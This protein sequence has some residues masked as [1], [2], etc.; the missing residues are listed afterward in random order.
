MR[1][2]QSQHPFPA[3]EWVQE[4]SWRPS[5]LPTIPSAQ[6]VGIPLGRGVRMGLG[7]GT[8]PGHPM[9]MPTERGT[10]VSLGSGWCMSLGGHRAASNGAL[11]TALPWLWSPE[12]WSPRKSLRGVNK[13]PQG[14]TQC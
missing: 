1:M 14:V 9:V 4:R 5:L 8:D 3:L 12:D 10:W 11:P 7:S 6:I 13:G 2:M